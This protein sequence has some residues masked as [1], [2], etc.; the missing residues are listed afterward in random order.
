MRKPRR[1][2][3]AVLRVVEIVIAERQ[4][5]YACTGD[6]TGGGVAPGAHAGGPMDL[7]IRRPAARLREMDA[8]L[9]QITADERQ[10]RVALWVAGDAPLMA[11]L[12]QMA[13]AEQNAVKSRVVVRQPV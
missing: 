6:A 2:A 1:D 5:R 7:R 4:R 13:V 3:L 12:R 10:M 8:V 9:A 11:V